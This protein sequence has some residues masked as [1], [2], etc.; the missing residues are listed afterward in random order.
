MA[1][2]GL[3][4]AQVPAPTDTVPWLAPTQPPELP[5]APAPPPV[6]VQPAPEQPTPY[7]WPAPT[8]YYRP[9]PGPAEL[10]YQEGMQAPPG[11]ELQSRRSIPLIVSG[12]V[13]LGVAWYVAFVVGYMGL[14]L[15]SI[16]CSGNDCQGGDWALVMVPVIGPI[17]GAMTLD[18]TATARTALVMD[19]LAQVGGIVMLAMGIKTVSHK[20]VRVDDAKLNWRLSP[21]RAG[22]S[23][24]GLGVSATF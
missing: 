2:C 6:V 4:H 7:Y 11:Y 10:P 14:V 16:G 18:T 22:G 21:I 20:W 1:L 3:A 12:S 15:E 19:G 17:M 9:P 24:M 8:Q 5:P 13:T 23:G